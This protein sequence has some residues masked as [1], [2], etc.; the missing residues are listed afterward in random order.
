MHSTERL[1]TDRIKLSLPA[2]TVL[3]HAMYQ[4][5]TVLL[6][7][8]FFFLL[9]NWHFVRHRGFLGYC[10]IKGCHLLKHHEKMRSCHKWNQNRETASCLVKTA[11]CYDGQKDS[12]GTIPPEVNP[13][14]SWIWPFCRLRFLMWFKWKFCGWNALVYS[15]FPEGTTSYSQDWFTEMLSSHRC[16][17]NQWDLCFRH[18]K[19]HKNAKHLGKSSSKHIILRTPN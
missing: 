14:L 9:Q 13:N 5:W 16:C 6:F 18:I 1:E 11:L 10:N 7:F 2:L 3:F 15:L 19:Y 8:L 4:S 17:W 12:A